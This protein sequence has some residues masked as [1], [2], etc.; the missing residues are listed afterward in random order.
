MNTYDPADSI[1]Y[2]HLDRRDAPSTPR[3]EIGTRC[4]M[5]PTGY[6]NRSPGTYLG[7]ARLRSP[8]LPRDESPPRGRGRVAVPEV[9]KPPQLQPGDGRAAAPGTGDQDTSGRGGA[10]GLPASIPG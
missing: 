8:A 7:R 4:T 3:V 2:V 10:V 1:H 9:P 6:A 5:L